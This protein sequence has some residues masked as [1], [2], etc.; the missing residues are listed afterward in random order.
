MNRRHFLHMALGSAGFAFTS[1]PLWAAMDHS[2]H[3][4]HASATPAMPLKIMSENISLLAVE[5]L[6]AGNPHAVLFRLPN[7]SPKTAV[8]AATLTAEPFEAELVPGKKTVVWAYNRNIP[9]PLIEAFEGDTV[10][11]R[12]V[13]KL[14]QA[15]TIHWHGMPVPADQ[16]GNPQDAVPP[17]GERL[18][19]FTLPAGS[20]GTY[21]YHPHP[22]GDT[23]EQ[24]YRGLAGLFIVRAKDDVLRHLAEQHL[25]ISDLRL[26]SDVSIPDND[27]NDWMNG[28]EGQFA[29]V[30][31]QREPVITVGAVQRWRIWNACSARYLRLAVP[32]RKI[33]LVGSDG[34][35]LERAQIVDE[36]LLAP[37]E[38]AEWIVAGPEGDASLMALAYDRSKMGKV[39]PERDMKLASIKFTQDSVAKLP[40]RLRTLPPK[41]KPVA[42]K[43]VVFSEIMS[44]EGGQ[45]GMQFLVNGK[46]YDMKRVDL[47][48]RVGETELWEIV[49][50]SHMD[51][52]FHI[53]GTQFEILDTTL[54]GKTISAPWR[55]HKDT[56]NL[57]PYQSARILI[58]QKHRGLRM[59]HCH[60]LE[61][62]GLG[63]MGQVLVK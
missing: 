18:Y 49:N 20:A 14:A 40:E 53:H 38:R 45:H 48:S 41:I 33:I 12:F 5:A 8:V 16:D 7:L 10:E 30:N 58:T 51:H 4:G 32:S 54:K 61:H 62:E 29:L 26:D 2:A 43:R 3:A 63:M 60:I 15:S 46:G 42:K 36:L 1:N 6:P 56:F 35:L 22:H 37:G 47:T 23:P 21:W 9:G 44:M 19:R 24:V 50:D 52:P 25:V 11:I 34:G 17:G 13:N 39:A 59:F 55:A 28:R 57:K 31:G 27:R